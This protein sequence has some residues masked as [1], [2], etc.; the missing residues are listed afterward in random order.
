MSALELCGRRGLAEILG[1][2]VSQTINMQAAGLIAPEEVIDGRYPVFSVP[3]AKALREER[4]TAAQKAKAL[5][6]KRE[7]ARAKAPR[8]RA[9]T[10]V[11]SADA[12]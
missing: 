1:V 3:K 8:K 2:S 12:V 5:R 4:D 6:A 7:A 10:Q 11:N 9:R